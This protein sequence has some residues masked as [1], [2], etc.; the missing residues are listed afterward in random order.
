MMQQY[1]AIKARHQD[2]ILFFRL[3]D[4]YEMFFEDAQVASQALSLTLTG[5]GKGEQRVPMCGIPF[6]SAEGYISKLVKQGFKVAICEQTEPASKDSKGP[7]TRDVVRIITP[8]TAQL[9]PIL[10]A[11]QPNYLVAVSQHPLGIGFAYVD[12]S[13]GAFFCDVKDTVGAAL[14]EIHRLGA[15]ELLLDDALKG[16]ISHAVMA[17]F[18]P[19]Q[20]DQAIAYICCHF[21]IQ[22]IG[23]FNIQ[24]QRPAFAAIVAILDYLNYTQKGAFSQIKKIQRVDHQDHCFFDAGVMDHL[25]I[26]DKKNGLYK[27]LNTTKTPLGARCLQRYLRYP[28]IEQA[29]I[30]NRQSQV[31]HL[32]AGDHLILWADAVNGVHD[33]ERLTSR[34]CAKFQNPHDFLG[35][36]HSLAALDAVVTFLDE[37]GD[38][39][40]REH[41]VLSTLMTSPGG[42]N[43]LKSVLDNALLDTV[44]SHIRDGGIF[45]SGYSDELDALCQSFSDVRVWIKELEPQLK[46]SLGI[47]S[48]KVGFNK[49]F[50]YYIEIP[51]AQKSHVP[52]SFIRKQTLVNAERYITPE[53]KEKEAILLNAQS[54]QVQIEQGLYSELELLMDPYVGA[55]QTAASIIAHVDA[56]GALAQSSLTYG[57]TR[58]VVHECTHKSATLKGLWH[59][60][61]AAKQSFIRNTVAL[62]EA[63]PFMLITGPNMAGKSTIMRSVA[64]CIILGQMG[65]YVPAESAEFGL[66]TSIY[67]RIGA[68]DK[69]AQGQS[70]FMVE[71]VEM[72]TIC[73]NATAHSLI[74]L[75]EVGR[76][77][78]TFDGVSIAASVTEYL[79]TQIQARTLFATHYHELTA[80]ADRYSQIQNTSMQIKEVGDQLVFSYQLVPGAAHKSYGVMVAKMAGLPPEIIDKATA[81][82]QQFEQKSADGRVVQLTLF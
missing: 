79:V 30:L 37:L 67:T 80:L 14:A 31:T 41:G 4:F 15:N 28:L 65:S 23:I 26:F 2:A 13:T 10:D 25:G 6:H 56:M 69:L 18:F 76:G 78:S 22:D 29:A 75:D 43:E 21:N 61:V 49:V 71:M 9:D 5:R 59:P 8:G 54:Q 35:L 66:V 42:L 17:P 27:Q 34:I 11:T 3:G 16:Q 73:Q 1:K 74:L 20:E 58:P 51:N 81:W 36:R 7:T 39:F 45:K 50:G 32:M 12:V 60:V 33:I 48:L 52:A 44:P 77:T 40:D 46:A 82:L 57:F 53:L 68:N 63:H 70:T 47:K 64:L 62:S 72:A 38:H 55:L 19:F 24:D